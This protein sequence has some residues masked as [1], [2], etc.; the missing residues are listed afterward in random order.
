M[1]GEGLSGGLVGS[2]QV[3]PFLPA[4]GELLSLLRQFT[5]DSFLAPLLQPLCVVAPGQG[6]GRLRRPQ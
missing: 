4:G 3:V 2:L 1:C 6:G 5:A